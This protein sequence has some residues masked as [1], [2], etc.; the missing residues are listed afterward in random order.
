MNS[1]V[2]SIYKTPNTV[3][4]GW[5]REAGADTYKLYVSSVATVA[6]MVLLAQ[7]IPDVPHE[8]PT[9]RGKVV[10][11]V[12]ISSVQAAL[13]LASTLTFANTAFYFAITY[14]SGGVESSLNN[15][16]IVEVLPVGV[17]V[18]FMKDDPAINRHGYVFSDEDYKWYKMSGSTKGALAV[19]VS[20]Y[21]K[22]NITSDFT[23][24]GTNISTI[25]SYLSDA[26][27]GSP[28]KLTSYT[29][30]GGLVTKIVISDSTV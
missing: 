15:S 3:T 21:Y 11:P 18:K 17:T 22:V 7:N 20:D 4:L 25:K 5:A 9:G 8:Q 14:V 16:T 30:G 12:S 19:D 13:S 24:D 1:F 28:A 2:E 26:T 23:Y 27:T 6:S 10:Y 29:Y